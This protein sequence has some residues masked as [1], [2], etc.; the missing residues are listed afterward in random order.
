MECFDHSGGTFDGLLMD[1]DGLVLMVLMECFDHSGGATTRA[2]G[3]KLSEEWG[4]RCHLEQNHKL[5]NKEQ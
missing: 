1:F 5:N 2:D 3:R 4:D